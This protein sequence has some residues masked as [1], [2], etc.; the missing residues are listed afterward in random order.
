MKGNKKQM[1]I[2][3]LC[4]SMVMLI[5]SACGKTEEPVEVMAD[6]AE[7]EVE[8]E[9]EI[10]EPTVIEEKGE[11]EG[12]EE[13]TEAEETE[14]IEEEPLAMVP[15]YEEKKLEFCKD[16]SLTIQGTRA[17]INNEDDIEQVDAEWIIKSIDISDPENGFQTITIQHECTG[18]LWTDQSSRFLFNISMPSARYCDLNSGK[19]FPTIILSEDGKMGYQ[20]MVEWDGQTYEI[21]YTEGVEWN[22]GTEWTPDGKGGYILPSTMCITDTFVVSEGYEGLG[23]IL[24]PLTLDA[25]SD[26]SYGVHDEQEFFIHEI[27]ELDEGSIPFDMMDIYK[28]LKEDSAVDDVSNKENSITNAE[29]PKENSTSTNSSNTTPKQD[30]KKEQQSTHTHSYTSSISKSPTCTE[31][32]IMTYTCD[33]GSSYT[34][35]IPASGH[36]W[37]T[38]TETISHPSTGHYETVTK[39]EAFC[40][41][42]A[43]GFQSQEEL[44]AHLEAGCPSQSGGIREWS[45]EIWV[46]D[47]EPWEETIT[48]TKCAVCGAQG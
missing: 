16:T 8:A 2:L 46:V 37:T 1:Q 33:C 3:A 47:N 15:Y 48:V 25:M 32:G 30:D 13:E 18:Y 34:E 23:M 7:V 5:L 40:G 11:E 28:I 36:Q 31:N 4:I 44:N 26:K 24:S 17:D 22:D 43:S 19:C 41:C 20:T 10:E 45:E 12:K 27:L 39:K 35:P 21:N 29:T 42:G 38:T 6:T 14:E 9:P